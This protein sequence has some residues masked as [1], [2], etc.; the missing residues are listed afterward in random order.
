MPASAA[1]S[2]QRSARSWCPGQPVALAAMEAV[3]R[4]GQRRPGHHRA[5]E[6]GRAARWRRST[7]RP[8]QL[9]AYGSCGDTSEAAVRLPPVRVARQHRAP[10]LRVP[11]HGRTGAPVHRVDAAAGVQLWRGSRRLA[12]LLWMLMLAIPFR[13][14]PTRPAGRWRSSTA[15]VDHLRLMRTAE[16][17]SRASQRRHRFTTLG[18][19]GLYAV[20]SLLFLFLVGREIAHGLRQAPAGL[21]E[22]PR[23]PPGPA[24]PA[25]EL[26]TPLLVRHRRAVHVVRLR[27]PGRVRPS[28]R[29]LHLF[30]AR[31]DRQRREVLAAIGPVWDGNEV[32]LIAS[33]GVLVFAFPPRVRRRVLRLLPAADDGALAARPGAGSPSSSSHLEK[34]RSGAASGTPCSASRAP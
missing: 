2:Y 30:V 12:P 9:L 28:R 4:E 7:C 24:F 31:T 23:P 34:C 27:G 13:T 25:R 33:G 19:L 11:H 6:P 22:S 10:L 20:V 14:S 1:F 15:A 21:P 17:T 8:A 26:C 3:S 29:I 5:T 18:F 16:G 32:W